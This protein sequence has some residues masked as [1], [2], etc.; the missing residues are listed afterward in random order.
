MRQAG[1]LAAP[2]LIAL[3]ENVSRLA[4]D[5]ER[6]RALAE[7]V[8]TRW[9]GA[10]DP[11]AVRTNLVVFEVDDPAA[12]LAH[13]EAHGVLGGT[14]APGVVRLVTHLD[15]DDDAILIAQK[16]IASSP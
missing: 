10:L 9:P 3:E 4:D 6:A 8:A 5:H 15:L 1:V 16:A 12:L 2:G 11:D 13:L 7:S 14:L